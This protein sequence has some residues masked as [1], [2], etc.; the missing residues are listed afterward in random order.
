MSYKKFFGLIQTLIE[1]LSED[2]QIE[3]QKT[4][5]RKCAEKL[6]DFNYTVLDFIAVCM[7]TSV[8]AICFCLLRGTL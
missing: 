1:F 3:F 2:I 6:G 4:T 5:N 8:Y 7:P